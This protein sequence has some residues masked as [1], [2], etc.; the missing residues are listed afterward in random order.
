MTHN[1]QNMKKS[2]QLS[3]SLAPH[4]FAVERIQAS[5]PAGQTVAEIIAGFDK[6][7]VS[8]PH[9]HVYIDGGYIPRDNWHAVRP[10]AGTVLSLRMVPMGGGG[11]KNPLR[12]VLSL[13][14]VAASPM[15]A[16]GIAGALGVTAG[17]TFMGISAARVITA[18]VNLLGRLTL[19]ALAPPGK[20]RFGAGLQESPTLFIQGARNQAYPFARVP[21]VLGKHR[22]VP[23]LGAL[24]YTET[25]GNDQY[26]R[27]IFVWGYGPLHISDIKIGETPIEQFEGVDIETRY[28]YPDDAPLT[29]YSNSVMQTDMDI[30]LR[31]TDGYVTRTTETDADEISVD[32]T[33]PRGLVFFNGSGNKKTTDV[34]LEVQ[35]SPAGED[36][37]SAPATTYKPVAAQNLTLHA[38]PNGYKKPG[39]V[40]T[41]QRFDRIFLDTAS[42]KISFVAGPVKRLG[43]D[44][45]A[46]ALPA[47][48]AGSVP[49][50]HILRQSSDGTSIAGT[51]ITD[52]RGVEAIDTYFEAET[53]FAVSP[54]SGN[55]VSSAAGGLSFPGIHLSAKQTSALRHAVTF[56]VPR[57][58][59]DV[60]LRRITADADDDKTFNDTVWTALRTTRNSYPVK[61]QN[62][63]VTA[64]R[65]KATDQL[66]GMVDRLNGIVHS[67]LPDW[68]GESWVEQTTSN[69]ASLYR[70][71][72]QGSANARP[73]ANAR[74]D[75]QRLQAWHET[76]AAEGRAFN[77]VIDYDVSV[78]E[79]LH[80][81]AATGRASPTILDG[82]WSIIEDRAQS[83]PIQ[84]FTPYNTYGF[85]GRKAFDDVPEALRIR[86]INRE[87]GW[88]QDERLVF[89]DGFDETTAA[90]Y[91]SL[92]LTGVTD[93]AQAWRDGRYHLATALLRPETYSFYCD[94]E[95][96]VCT[97][98]DLIRFTHDVPLFGLHSS[99]VAA[100]IVDPDDANSVT[101]IRMESAMTMA[102]NESYAARFRLS[103]GSS[104]V[105]PLLTAAGSSTDIMLATA[106]PLATAP[107]AGDLV[108]AGIAGRES[109]ELV[110]QAI[111][112]QSDLS[113]RITCV[114]AAPAIHT[115]DQGTMPLFN[116]QMTLPAGLQRPPTPQL[117]QIQA[118]AD[119][120][121][122]HADGSVTSQTI[123]HLTA[124]L[125]TGALDV[126]VQ[127]RAAGESFYHH[128]TITSA[129]ATRVAVTDL[130]VTD[131]YD[132]RI[133]YVTP[134]GIFSEPLVIA[135]Y[136]AIDG[137][138]PPP[139]VTTLNVHTVGNTSYLVWEIANAE[140]ITAFKLRFAAQTSGASWQTATDIGGTLP[141]SVRSTAQPARVGTYFLK[142][143][144][145]NGRESTQ[146]V[147]VITDIAAISGYNAVLTVSEGPAFAGAFNDIITLEDTLQLAEGY[148]QGQ[149]YF[150]EEIDL[151]RPYTSLVTAHVAATGIDRAESVDIW[152]NFDKIDNVDNNSAPGLWDVQLQIKTTTD[153]RYVPA[154][155]TLT[156][157]NDFSHT[158]WTKTRCNIS[159]DA[160]VAPDG[161]T[162]ADKLIE[163]T[164]TNTHTLSQPTSAVDNAPAAFGLFVKA[165]ERGFIGIFLSAAADNLD[166]ALGATIDLS[167][168]STSYLYTY[169]TATGITVAAED[170]GGGW[171]RVAVAGTVNPAGSGDPVYA[172]IRMADAL[173]SLSYA[174][175]GSSGIYIW[176]AHVTQTM[177][178][179]APVWSGWRDFTMGEYTAR[180][181]L[182]RAQLRSEM[183]TVTPSVSDIT[184]TIDMPDRTESGK[185]IASDPAGST[186]DFTKAFRDTPALAITPQNMA[187]GDYYTIT[188]ITP[189]GFYVRFFNSSGSGI[190]R[191][192]DYV[193]KGFGESA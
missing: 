29:L 183:S 157:A 15:I 110:V 187:T 52:E 189:A 176:G 178:P 173:G 116:S 94:I 133:R 175:D 37:W 49:L 126:A 50:A 163:D 181:F 105:L 23:P 153:P 57:G 87:K 36:D 93:P 65:I 92:T 148:T 144:G 42:G 109:V 108:L 137:T 130:D 139:D 141:A 160:A 97:R 155:Q 191:N 122:H 112:P 166:D 179:Y 53:D 33:L 22:F 182:F 106:Q 78:R 159:A 85:Q 79:V 123:L 135:G 145:S 174:G 129:T 180:G 47:I 17:A 107:A 167:D 147:S 184:V 118:G 149:Y 162:G 156:H 115:A 43:H 125:Y 177:L 95:H 68:D 150:A 44:G 11:G 76:C 62:L 71:V 124:P 48:P 98:G 185:D 102:D 54:V 89:R 64:L 91:E 192:F 6:S 60:R 31:Q 9:A 86:F 28:G 26:I 21:K 168:G 96:L 25:A 70:H 46:P 188:D 88:M 103:D 2:G 154:L 171:W 193:A 113:A 58:K 35:Y 101:G 4:P 5:I 20:P 82:K 69:P 143:I 127:I 8:L 41:M 140:G 51:A 45:E 1:L 30:T 55:V 38:K 16:A 90:K 40:N 7:A 119:T 111:E 56:K 74:L 73:L 19:N 165:A 24:P 99:R 158:D 114:D 67:I 128:A 170:M 131:M 104:A 132:L 77:A 83:V 100:V 84:H 63:A 12:T 146:A 10:K 14:L 59:Y 142:A 80:D 134:D 75:L 172:Q 138:T 117:R 186:I 121:I 61:M 190:S 32:I 161:S 81:I 18:G 164:S 72:L 151:G 66:N 169:G 34:Q 13:A 39:H 152:P 27:M 136:S 3:V 120:A